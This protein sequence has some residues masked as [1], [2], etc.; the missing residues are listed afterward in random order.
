[1]AWRDAALCRG[2]LLDIWYAPLDADNQEQYNA[3]AREV[4]HLC[5]VWIEC[6]K[7]GIN[8]QWG[9]WGGLT[10]LERSV[11]KDKP[12]KTAL[13]PHGT[14]TRYRQGCRCDDCTTVHTKTMKQ[15]KN[16]D[17]VPN[18]G[19]TEYDLFTVLYRLLQ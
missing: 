3:V 15:D 7:N 13:R 4:C 1:M 18:T 14:P 17:V 10:P 12:K 11:F 5:P 8:E 9:I 16:L 6:L 19:D 2:K